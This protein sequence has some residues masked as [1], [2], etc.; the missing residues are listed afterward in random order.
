MKSLNRSGPMKEELFDELL[1]TVQDV[2]VEGAEPSFTWRANEGDIP[3]VKELRN[4]F[5]LSQ[6]KF[7]SLLGISVA[8]LRNWEQGRR[9][10]EGPA[11]VLLNVAARNPEAVLNAVW[12]RE[13]EL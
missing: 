7:A 13:D 2:E 6:D 11:R 12:T 8:T 5:H 1:R 4:R 3:D 9:M 10:P